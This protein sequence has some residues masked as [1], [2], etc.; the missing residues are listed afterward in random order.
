VAK[1]AKASEA[2]MKRG[3][4]KA[5]PASYQQQTEDVPALLQK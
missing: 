2:P 3:R 5:A 1:E 4:P